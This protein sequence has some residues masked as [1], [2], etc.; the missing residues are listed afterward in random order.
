MKARLFG[1]IAA[2]MLVG[3]L[4]QATSP[5][6]AWHPKPAPGNPML[7]VH[8]G[9]GSG[10]QW[11]TQAMRFES[12]G[13]PVDYIDVEEY[14]SSSIGT[15]MPQVLTEIDQH[16]ADLKAE[17][18]ADQVDLIGHSL[19]TTVSAAYLNSSPARA[20]NVA[21]Y[22]NIDGQTGPIPVPTLALW[23]GRGAPGREIVGATNV[24]I[25]DVTHVQCATSADSF[26]EMY[27]FFTGNE[28]RSKD[29]IPEFP[30]FIKLAGRAVIFPQNVGV[31][32]GTLEIWLVN[33][34]TGARIG[35]KP[36]AT[37]PLSGDG[38]WGPF[39]A[40]GGASYEFNILR[41]GYSPHP[42]Y[43]EPF[44]RSDYLIRLNTSPEPSGGVSAIM[45]RTDVTTN[46]VIG[47][48]MELWG[49]QGAEND[50]L[51][52]NGTN[53]IS[54]ATNPIARLVNYMFIYDQDADGV[55]HLGV[56]IAPFGTPFFS[57][58]DLVVPGAN[59]PNAT[60]PV[61]L[62]SRTGGGK[63]EVVNVPNWASSAVRRISI[64]F[65]DYSQ[66]NNSWLE[67]I[68]SLLRR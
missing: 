5:A 13:Y 55:S 48:N 36:A 8:G 12:N 38:S 60:V 41:D 19:G 11:E 9:A 64:Q 27:K 67:Y 66:E 10:A 20:A 34:R 29:I 39:T 22:V 63:A 3:V 46:F 51:T 62:I 50:V 68:L 1:L 15:I 44:L 21:H 6:Q 56:P 43:Y 58:V 23:A 61:V 65:H 37:Y 28:P 32:D 25:P 49:D 54:P 26:V 40:I 57:G 33:P 7:F 59:P 14:D 16:I 2:A 17:T 47:R 52:I 53:I 31:E 18:G 4:F 45:P 30:L 35:W 24:T 42:F